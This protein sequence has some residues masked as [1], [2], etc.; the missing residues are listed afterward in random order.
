MRRIVNWIKSFDSAIYLLLILFFIITVFSFIYAE[1]IG[2]WDGVGYYIYLRSAVFD[3]DIDF[4]NDFLLFPD[5]PLSQFVT[6]TATGKLA[7]PF[8]VGPA[9]F[10][11]PFFLLAHVLTLLANF[12]GA[13]IPVN[14]ISGI[15]TNFVVFASLVYGFIGIYL[16][17]RF[18]QK[19]FANWISLIAVISIWLA[20]FLIYYFIYEPFYSHTISMFIVTLF[21]YYW[22][23]T[24]QPTRTVRQWL[25]LG[26]ISGLMLLVRWQNGIFMLIPAIESLLRYLQLIKEKSKTTLFHLLTGNIGFLILVFLVALPQLIAWKI[27]YG[28]YIVVPVGKW[29]IQWDK[30]H[31]S[32]ILFSSRN[33]LFT[34][35]PITLFATLG[36]FW[37]YRKDRKLTLYFAL[38]FLAMLYV[39]SVVVEWWCGGGYGYRRLDGIIPILALGLAAVLETTG[40][41]FRGKFWIISSILLFGLIY[42]NIWFMHQF[43]KGRIPHGQVVRF[44]ELYAQKFGKPFLYIGNPFSFPANYFFSLKYGVP[45]AYFDVVVGKYLDFLD[46]SLN[47]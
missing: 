28:H 11:L 43:R 47:G 5:S 22:D 36:L 10:W 12:L 6:P 23:T 45:P 39:N 1:R 8:S 4:A 3:H 41:W 2:L 26:I 38:G 16:C 13:Q 31:I 44:S 42:W 25:I 27:I 29:F 7:N 9:I 32:E 35:S 46:G 21:F 15:Y 30:P 20:T 40:K 18:C 34:W 24:R 14:G 19:Y 37:F 17:Y 33:G